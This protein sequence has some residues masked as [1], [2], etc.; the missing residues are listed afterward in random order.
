[1]QGLEAV[2]SPFPRLLVSDVTMYVSLP[3]I[4][5]RAG[6]GRR[7]DPDAVVFCQPTTRIQRALTADPEDER[8]RNQGL[9]IHFPH[10]PGGL[11]SLLGR[12]LER[13]SKLDFH[14]ILRGISRDNKDK[15][16]KSKSC[17]VSA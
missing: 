11:F 17:L 1:M 5:G 4:A 2:F 16:I 7:R 12:L 15:K 10:T 8:W 13:I 9:L 14:V 6:K 3:Q